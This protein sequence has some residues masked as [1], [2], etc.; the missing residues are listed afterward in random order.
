MIRARSI[1]VLLSLSI[2][3]WSA[4]QT[5]WLEL[6]SPHYTVITDAGE[7]RGRDL[8]LRFEQMRSVF[9]GVLTKERLNESRP[10]TILAFNDDKLYF[11]LAPLHDGKPIVASGFLL[12]AEDQDFIALNLTESDS[13]RSVAREF[14]RRLLD[15]NYPPAQAWFDEGLLQYFSTIRI[16]NRQV[17][18][19]GDPALLAIPNSSSQQGA[20]SFAKLLE[21]QQWQPLP[22]LFSV[23]RETSKTGAETDP[24][25]QAECWIVIHYL[26]HQKKLP[27]TGT[28]FG[29]VLNQHLPVEDA[30]KQAYGMSSEQLQEAVKAYFRQ[31]PALLPHDG[32]A[33][34]ETDKYPVPVTLDD[35]IITANPLP[36]ADARAIYA[37]VQLRVPE[38]HDAGLKTLTELAT[39]PTEADKKA[40]VKT[41]KRIGEDQEQLPTSAIGNPTAHRFLAWDKVEHGQFEDAFTELGDAASLNQRDMWV[42]YYL[43]VAKYRLSRAKH[44]EILGLANMMLDLK[45]VL[46]W[47]SELADAYDLLAVA[48]NEGGSTTAAMESERAAIGLSPRSERY[49]LHLAQIY[50][51][52]KK[53]PAATA[54]LDRLKISD[55][56]QTAATAADMLN[57]MSAEKK[58]GVAAATSGTGSQP[59]YEE[60][61]SPFAALDEEASKREAMERGDQRGTADNRTTTFVKGR[62]VAVDCSNAP[63]AIL[64]VHSG[65]ATLK[66][67]AADYKN[68]LLIGEDEFSCSWRD[69]QVTANYKPRGGGDGDLVS[70][71]IR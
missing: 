12:S 60:Q 9:A 17:E 4:N 30:I 27:E 56:P 25:Y 34:G 39:T 15:F 31:Q 55:N 33:K 61:K 48:R 7:R 29:L 38:R 43:C 42:R 18:I 22:D 49:L 68:L 54:L 41:R 8:A 53:Y 65:S 5:P 23:K 3:V 47:N 36:E 63:A 66:L 70:L 32:T 16:D 20:Q 57:Q 10:L 26:V 69:R 2:P 11:Q 67:R 50:V 37:G 59:K 35:S 19:G 71:E 1:L 40:D 64:T 13:W 14:A 6:H 58:Y 51:T 52:A 21:T 62:L 45:A 24:L 28:Y 44:N 46:D